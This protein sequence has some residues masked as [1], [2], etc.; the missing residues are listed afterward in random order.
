M[1][2]L[3]LKKD[4]TQTVA[5][6]IGQIQI[7]RTPLE[8]DYWINLPVL[9]GHCQTV[10]TSALKNCKGCLP[11]QEKRRFHT[12][13]LHKPIAALAAAVMPD[14]T[15]VDS[16]CGDLNFEEG[17]TPIQTD[18][19]FLGEDM[20]QLDAFGCQL[21]GIDLTDVPYIG[22]AEQY[23]A[24]QA[25][26]TD[27]DIIV[28]TPPNSSANLAGPGTVG[29]IRTSGLVRNLTS[30]VQQASACSACFGNLVHALYRL[31]EEDQPYRGPLFI[32]QDYRG[33]KL[34]GIGIGNCCNGARRF[35]PGCP[36][37][38]EQILEQ[39]LA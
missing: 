14:L 7:C 30:Q 16:I 1:Q 6:A 4:P 2:L 26:V 37:S 34:D 31:Q 25:S 32:G 10:M 29:T 19:L 33:Q 38:A 8:I 28:V 22:L 36:P 18:R 11:D 5:T 9:K 27:D 13:G 35:V 3:D 24:G 23:G 12:M 17:G 20:V 21:L 39:L 15:I